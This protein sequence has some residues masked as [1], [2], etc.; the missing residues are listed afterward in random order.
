MQSHSRQSRKDVSARIIVGNLL[1]AP[2][3]PLS[4]WNRQRSAPSNCATRQISENASR[5]IE[6]SPQGYASGL[7]TRRMAWD[8]YRRRIGIIDTVS[9]IHAAQGVVLLELAGG[10]DQFGAA[11]ADQPQVI[12]SNSA[13]VLRFFPVW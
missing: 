5:F 7:Q 6:E 9:L 1:L 4:V 13:K 10:L 3:I 2:R 12:R 11:I 8:H